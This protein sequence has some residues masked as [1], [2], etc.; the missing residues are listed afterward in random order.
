VKKVVFAHGLEGSPQG[1]K[2]MY[3]RERFD[4]IA[5]WLGELDLPGQVEALQKA[6]PTAG[7]AVV[8]GSSLGGL[9]ALGLANRCPDRIHHLVLLAPAVGMERHK[10]EHPDVEAKRPGLFDQAGRFST[11]SVPPG[12]PCTIIHGM[13]DSMVRFE[14]VLALAKRSPSSW[15]ILVHDDHPLLNAKDLICSVVEQEAGD[16]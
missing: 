1:T 9:A 10:D 11:L 4:A 15:L 8:V 7:T 6:L 2:A 16:H 13:E 3:L 12:L 5:P 14:E